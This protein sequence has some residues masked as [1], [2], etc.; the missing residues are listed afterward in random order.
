MGKVFALHSPDSELEF[1]PC[2]CICSSN[3]ASSNAQGIAMG[4][5]WTQLGIAQKNKI[6]TYPTKA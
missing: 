4:K 2:H 1:S 3:P 5:A 6:T